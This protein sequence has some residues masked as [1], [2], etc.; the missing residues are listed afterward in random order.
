MNSFHNNSSLKK[1]VIISILTLIPLYL[2]GFYKNGILLYQKDLISILMVPKI[3]YFL[4]LSLLAYFITNKITSKHME[5]NLLFLSLFIIPLFMPFKANLIIYFLVIFG[6]LLFQKYFNISLVILLLSLFW[7]FETPADTLSLYNFSVMDLLMGRG[8]GGI[9]VT[10]IILGLVIFVLLS[11]LTD[12]KYLVASFS[13]LTYFLLSLV[14][15]KLS[16][17]TLG[18]PILTLI[19]IAPYSKYTPL[20]RKY[21]II[22]GVLLAFLGVVLMFID[23]YYGMIL[24]CFIFSIGYLWYQK[25]FVFGKKSGILNL[26]KKK[27][28]KG[29]V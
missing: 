10:S 16:Y 21:Q 24:S 12:Y 6:I 14:L 5:Y 26:L 9:G 18:N 28:K 23:I 15:G 11:L 22:Y 17:L 1:Q 27:N 3:F 29:S 7:S 20:E 4:G 25:R 19:L 13:L 2:Y 8:I